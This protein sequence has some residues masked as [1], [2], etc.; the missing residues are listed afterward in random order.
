MLK[1]RSVQETVIG[2]GFV[3]VFAF[4]VP[5]VLFWVYLKQTSDAP[6]VHLK[7]SFKQAVYLTAL[8]VPVSLAICVAVSVLFHYSNSTYT[9]CH[10]MPNPLPSVSA[11]TGNNIPEKWIFRFGVLIAFPGLLFLGGIWH[12]FF[13][14]HMPATVSRVVL[15]IHSIAHVLE[16]ISLV[17]IAN[18]TSQEHYPIH[19]NSFISWT[20]FQLIKSTT[21]LYMMARCTPHPQ[22]T[23][24]QALRIKKAMWL[25]NT[26]FV[27]LSLIVFVV[28]NI[29]CI[30]YMYA[31]YAFCEYVVIASNVVFNT[32]GCLDFD[33]DCVLL[34]VPLDVLVQQSEK[35]KTT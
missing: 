20:I 8:P 13:M 4:M 15:C 31:V 17:F 3:F 34:F 27:G 11:A 28:H 35:Y 21:H 26:L 1:S 6:N 22:P 32:S 25:I 7:I 2:I 9:H 23:G 33:M 5:V 24:D 12:R 16:V 10:P 19:E 18:V 14:R 30:P 29:Q